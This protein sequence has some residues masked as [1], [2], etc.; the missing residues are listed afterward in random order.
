MAQT[1]EADAQLEPSADESTLKAQ[2][3]KITRF[4]ED[5]EK[6]VTLFYPIRIFSSF[7]P[8]LRFSQVFFL[9]KNG[10]V[11]FLFWSSTSTMMADFTST[12]CQ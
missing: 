3:I 5:S 9:H 11:L 7:P 4:S 8:I 1:V 6:K 2:R 12:A 10:V